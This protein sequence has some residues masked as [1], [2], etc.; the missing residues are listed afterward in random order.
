MAYR[1]FIQIAYNG[2]AY[3]GWQIQ[4]NAT[5]VQELIDSGLAAISGFK[6]SVTGC[7]RT[8][9][10]VSA[11]SF[12]AHYDQEEFFSSEALLQ[13]AFRL[14]RFLPQDIVVYEIKPVLPGGH[15]RYS[16][17]W[18]E[19]EYLILRQKDPFN[20]HH[21]YFVHGDLDIEKMNICSTLLLGRTD[22]QC[23]S[24]VNTQVNNYLCDI[25]VAKWTEPD[26]FL[27]FT[28]RADRFLRNMVR[29]IVGTLLD[30]GRG[31]ISI[32]DF[33]RIIDSHDRGKAGYSVPA[34]G[35]KLTGVGYPEEIFSDKPVFFSPEGGEKIISHYYTDT[36]FHNGSGN[37][38]NK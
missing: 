23:F 22:F 10:G 21:A 18:R 8:D 34:K 1:Y 30:V 4:P 25:K 33:Q 27:K 2:S 17:T 20:Y 31:K 6:G 11:G 32:D 5:T 3:G 38:T 7:G 35:L 16:A 26:H 14:N 19:Y 9:A 37:E 28:I 13:L 29:A 12:F 24:K 36:K 15:A